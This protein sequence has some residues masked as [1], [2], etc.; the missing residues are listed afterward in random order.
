MSFLISQL[1]VQFLPS[2]FI[3][4]D[5]FQQFQKH[6]LNPVETLLFKTK[7][8]E[9]FSLQKPFQIVWKRT[10]A[11]G[12]VWKVHS[13]MLRSSVGATTILGHFQKCRNRFFS[14]YWKWISPLTSPLLA[15]T[16]GSSSA[17]YLN[18]SIIWMKIA[19]CENFRIFLSLR[20]YVK[21]IFGIL[22][23]QNRPFL[24]F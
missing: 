1:H 10:A 21:S 3:N 17:G 4:R 6:N 20:F 7:E 14:K 15:W 12:G 24:P 18:G 2:N 11:F 22:E 13:T 19:Q 23:V 8:G 16:F 9:D 5:K